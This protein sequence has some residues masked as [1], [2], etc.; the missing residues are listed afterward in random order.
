MSKIVKQTE[1]EL[2]NI[3]VEAIKKAIAD[4]ALPEAEIP[5]FN[6]E[7]PANK[8][9]G[10]YSTNVAM[11]GA[12]AFKKAPRMIAEAIES[13]IDLDGT[14][15]EK[16]E[17]AGPGFMN[18]FLSQQ[19]YSDVLKDIFACGKDYGKSDYGQGKRILVEFVSANPTGPMHI[20]NA[21][22]GAI[23]DCLASVLDWAGYD[24]SREFYVNDAGNQIEK[25]ATSLEVRYLQHFDSSVELPEDAYHGQDIVDHAENF[26]KEYGDKYVNADSKERRKA[27]VDYALPKNIAGLERDLKRYRITYDKWFR[28]STLHN[29]GSVQKVIDALKAKGVTYEQDGALWFKASEYGNDKDIVLVRANGLPTYIVPDIAYH[30]N[31][32]V[33]R[34]YDKAIDVL[35]ADHHG[36]VPRM[37]AA[38]TALGLDASRLDCVI[39]QM[40]RLVRDGETIKL[41][42]RSGK[43]ITLN[44][45]ID[46]VPLDAARFFFNL[47]EPNSHFDFDLELAAKES[48]EN[49]VYYVQYA[50]ARICSI[51]KKAQ[52]QGVE[53]RNPSDDELA[54]LNSKEEKDLIRHLSSLTDE[55]VSAAKS[56]DPAKITHYVIE[57]ATLFHKFYNAQRVM[58]D[59]KESL[60]QARL[61]LCKAVKDTIYNVLTMLKITAPEVM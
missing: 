52:E 15:F 22:G 53:L 5:Q 17:I 11:A 23:G 33:T 30:Y 44:T 19:F 47:R 28:E 24:V 54:L 8:D 20:G 1:N 16:V 45:L 21:R 26:I 56:Y 37:K 51:I 48:S 31:K 3:I 2:K 34:G 32:L 43:A 6:I 10:D 9:N 18:F 49:P 41:S 55:I 36:Y 40:V 42:K 58:L 50:H 46:E 7:K 38:L 27:L 14:V 57:L 35:G 29:D 4:G 60:M 12:R 39:M 13:C 59:D 25:F 61:F